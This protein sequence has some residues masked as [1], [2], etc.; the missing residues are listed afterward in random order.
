MSKTKNGL[1]SILLSDNF[2]AIGIFFVALF[3]RL[4][5]LT[6]FVT[7]D[8]A[9]WVIRSTAFLGALVNTDWAQTLQT[10]HPGVTT[11]WS[12]SIGLVLDYLLNHQATGSLLTFIQSLPTNFEHIDPTTL[13]WMRLPIVV[14]ASLSVASVFWFL[15]LLNKDVAIIA[16]LLLAFNPHHIGQSQ[17]LHH[18][19]LV[20]IFT[21]FS[22][23]LYLTALRQWSW[24]LLA[25]SGVAAGLAILS[26]STAYALLPF[27]GLV[28]LIEIFY[29]RQRWNRAILAGLIWSGLALLT[30]IIF[31][32][33]MW[34]APLAVWRTI[35]G[36]A[37]E[38]TNVGGLYNTMAPDFSQ[39]FPNLG[40]F[41]YPTN[42][43]LK[44]TPLMLAGLIGFIWWWQVEPKQ[45]NARWWMLHLLLWITLFSLMLTL[46]DKR[47]G[48]YL[49]PIYF[50]VC[51][52]AAFGLHLIYNKLKSWKSMSFDMGMLPA[53]VYQFGFVI[54]LLGFSVT[55]Y[56]Y[57]LPYYNPLVGG[58]W[59]APRLI[60]IGWGDGME[61]AAAWLNQQPNAEN[62]RVATFLGHTFQP[63][64]A[65]QTVELNTQQTFS[66]DYVLSYHRQIQ[67]GIPFAEFWQYYQARPPVF[68]LRTAGLDY[69]W[70]HKEPPLAS[71]GRKSLGNDLTL[72]A[73][74]TNQHMATP[75]SNLE[76]TLIWRGNTS[77]DKPVQVQLRD[78]L[79]QIRTESS[80]A[81]IID[82]AGPS[83]VEGHYNL[84]IPANTPRGK[85]LLWVQVGDSEWIEFA[86]IPVGYTESIRA[87]ATLFE[88]DFAH[89]IALKGFE[90]SNNTPTAG[91]NID[92]LLHWQA[93]QA[94]PYAFTTFVHLVDSQGNVVAQS[95]V[96]PGQG[97]WLTNTWQRN[98]W[99]ADQVSLSLPA[100]LPPGQ[101]QILV[102]WYHA[103]SGQRLPLADDETQNSVILSTIIINP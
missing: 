84:E 68:T 5:A 96:Q 81:P 21:M 12:G 56:P 6:K 79:G 16:A 45:S 102:G 87:I 76:V 36:W 35:F 42:W 60:R 9:R 32:P 33:A 74:T 40:I 69:V 53:N 70:L 85:H 65:G 2:I 4:L 94:M 22:I 61:E 55:Y 34:V 25:L 66:A 72:R 64:F 10:G 71:V 15:R 75:D 3:P 83:N 95:D 97:Q 91:Q 103:E 78:E 88:A 92:L 67:N 93:I 54:L 20:S 47:D 13:P 23:F 51:I 52:L 44:S 100:E 37:N 30:V 8:E 31:W 73:Y 17:L 27:I 38:S 11:M 59:L 89:R 29:K 57:Y 46:G 99:F 50:A 14:L 101:Y 24:L 26:K 63:F 48:R 98:E 82:P 19:A 62:L 18:D 1:S 7:S 58:S 28:F 90:I 39:G 80:P 41:F 43:L 49:L 77:L 86:S